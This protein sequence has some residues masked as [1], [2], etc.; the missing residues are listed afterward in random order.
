MFTLLRLFYWDLKHRQG[1][2]GMLQSLVRDCPGE[3]GVQ[4]RSRLYRKYFGKIGANLRVLQDVRIRNPQSIIAGDNLSLGDS[5][6][7]Q[8][9]GGIEFGDDVILGPGVK[10]WSA[11]HRF[12][13]SSARIADQGYDYK[14]VTIGSGVWIGANAFIMP[15]ATIGDGVVI[16]AGAVVGGKPIPSFKIVAGNPARVIGAR[17]PGQPA[18]DSM[19]EQDRS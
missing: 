4:L 2:F 3:F 12:D 8:A 14:K 7:L 11:N 9:A 10:I 13:N 15:G 17:D 19:A 5:N 18:S 6:F 16:S 1:R